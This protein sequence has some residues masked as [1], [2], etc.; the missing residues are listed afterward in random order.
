MAYF[1][2]NTGGELA[3]KLGVA[4][5]TISTWK[6]RNTIDYELLF[7]KCE[8]VNLNWLITGEG[9][10]LKTDTPL[11]GSP[12]L[13]SLIREKDKTII[14]MAEEIGKLKEQ[15]ASLKKDKNVG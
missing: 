9:E 13:I 7:A 12:D 10:M 8:S 15:V 4:P 6:V 11:A 2:I 14:E 5:S 3:E 1:Q